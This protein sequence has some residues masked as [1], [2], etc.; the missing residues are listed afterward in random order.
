L[1]AFYHFFDD[2]W[3]NHGWKQIVFGCFIFDLKK[4]EK[5]QKKERLGKQT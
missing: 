1:Y 2:C 4:A 3:K 5:L